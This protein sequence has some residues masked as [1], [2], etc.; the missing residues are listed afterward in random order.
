[1]FPPCL[2]ILKMLVKKKKKIPVHLPDFKAILIP[3]AADIG[4]DALKFPAVLSALP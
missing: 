4:T 2:V 3:A 1:M